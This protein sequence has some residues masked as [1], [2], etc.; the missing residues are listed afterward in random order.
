MQYISVSL[1]FCAVHNSLT[2]NKKGGSGSARE[3]RRDPLPPPK[4]LPLSRLLLL[5]IIIIY[6]LNFPYL[7]VLAL[8]NLPKPNCFICL[9]HLPI[10]VSHAYYPKYVRKVI[11]PS[12]PSMR[13]NFIAALY[14]A[15]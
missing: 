5:I 15:R 1:L 9:E 14:R 10:H 8:S 11:D 13:Q 3:K 12:S 2:Q 6:S 4:I 7:R